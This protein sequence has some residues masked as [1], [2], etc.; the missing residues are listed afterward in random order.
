[1]SKEIKGKE[2]KFVIHIPNKKHDYCLIKEKTH[3]K[4][5]TFEDNLRVAVDFKRP[6]YITKKSKR[7]HKDKR[8]SESMDNV[9]KYWSTENDLGKNIAVK[10]GLPSP[11]FKTLRDVRSSPYVYGI[12]LSVEAFIKSEYQKKYSDLTSNDSICVLDLEADIDTG[13][14]TISGIADSTRAYVAVHR[15]LIK[16]IKDPKSEL[17]RL[18]KKHFPNVKYKDIL[19]IEME[20]YDSEID[21]I[22]ATFERLHK[23][24][25]DRVVIWNMQYDIPKIMDICKKAF[26]DPKEIFSDPN[27]PNDVKYFKWKEGMKSFKKE[28]GKVD[29]I[30][31]EHQWDTVIAPASFTFVDAMRAY[32]QVRGG[33]SMKKEPDGVGLDNILKISLNLSKLKFGDEDKYIGPDFHRFM[34]K[35]KP[36][37]YIVYNIWDNVSI[38]C[39]EDKT[40]DIGIT[41]PLLAGISNYAVFDS[42]PK[43]IVDAFHIYA[44]K[45][46]RVVGCKPTKVDNNK[47]LGLDNWIVTLPANRIRAGGI[48]VDPS[49]PNVRSNIRGHVYDS[50]AVSAYPSATVVA[51]I[52]RDTTKREIIKIEGIE[53][54]TFKQ[55]NINIMF[56]P[57]NNLDY[58]NKMMNKP[59]IKQVIKI[60]RERKK[61]T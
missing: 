27:L 29:P 7:V 32:V 23:W 10:L 39:L 12:D 16:D 46:N 42:G 11:K 58:G 57:V 9:D 54:E 56:G 45:I 14:M 13:L 37:E 41:M 4:D 19:K 55:Q 53:K 17:D 43:R 25:P 31:F 50:D 47:I 44:E 21:M 18:Y 59:T 8:E 49:M 24:R 3:F 38:L 28:S 51:N 36:V 22:K 52:S 15:D 5:G 1:M 35:K 48:F 40:G 26:I 60:L 6:F 61:V 2:C 20:I 30:S 33:K 34:S